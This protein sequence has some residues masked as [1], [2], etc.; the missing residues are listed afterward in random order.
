MVIA[1]GIRFGRL[2][3]L[4]RCQVPPALVSMPDTN[5]AL[6]PGLHPLP[7]QPAYVVAPTVATDVDWALAPRSCTGFQSH[8]RVPQVVD[9]PRPRLSQTNWPPATQWLTLVGS[10]ENGAM[11][12]GFGSHGS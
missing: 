3:A 1:V 12:R 2:G 11:N 6:P 7:H 10:A 4:T 5:G 8:S 9:Q